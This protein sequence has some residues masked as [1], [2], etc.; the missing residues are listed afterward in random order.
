[1]K[2][3]TAAVIRRWLRNLVVPVNIAPGLPLDELGYRL[4]RAA[5]GLRQGAKSEWRSSGDVSRAGGGSGGSGRELRADIAH[6]PNLGDSGYRLFSIIRCLMTNSDIPLDRTE[7]MR[8]G[9]SA[10][11]L[12]VVT[13]L[14]EN[15]RS[16]HRLSSVILRYLFV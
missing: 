6:H 9:S 3:R 5:N 7:S 11:L 12:E 15:P 4:R 2:D 10:R 8:T 13:T 1:M 16:F 14:D